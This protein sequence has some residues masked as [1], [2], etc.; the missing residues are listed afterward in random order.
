MR[1]ASFVAFTRIF[2]LLATMSTSVFIAR[3][4]GADVYGTYATVLAVVMTLSLP[5]VGGLQTYLVRE[6]ARNRDH[7]ASALNLLMQM[8]ALSKRYALAVIVSFSIAMYF[9]W[10]PDNAALLMYLAIVIF[11]IYPTAMI[12]NYSAFSRGLGWSKAGTLFEFFLKP[13]LFL[14][15]LMALYLV[16]SL[17]EA[18]WIYILYVVSITICATSL[19]ALI[20][21]HFS[22][23]RNEFTGRSWRTV[24]ISDGLGFLTVIGGLQVL[25]ANVDLLIVSWLMEPTDVAIYK[26][27]LQFGVLVG[28]GLTIMNLVLQPILANHYSRSEMGLFQQELSFYT[29]INQA[30][31]TVLCIAIYY[32]RRDLVTLIFGPGYEQSADLIPYILA[33]QFVNVMAGSAGVVLNM[34]NN[35]IYV[36]RGFLISITTTLIILLL[37]IPEYGLKGAGIAYFVSFVTWNIYLLVKVKTTLGVNS[38]PLLHW[39]QKW[40]G[41]NE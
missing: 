32:F 16:D 39:A 40:M 22:Y 21:R 6:T 8:Q 35:H 5:I 12:Q 4:Y 29:L 30:S 41:R 10:K 19:L 27:A 33:G 3:V 25:L 9:L 18:Y 38:S 17:A 28:F 11:T 20:H 13:S 26:I 1:G 37:A 7:R 15:G 34:T 14:A 36:L 24:Y 31:T 23:N 2:G